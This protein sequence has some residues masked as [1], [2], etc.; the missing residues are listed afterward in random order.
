MVVCSICFCFVLLEFLFVLILIF[1]VFVFVCLF[2]VFGVLLFLERDQKTQS[3]ME[4]EV[5]T[6]SQELKKGKEYDQNIFM[7]SLLC[8]ITEY[9]GGGV[10]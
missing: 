4:K 1:L 6:I 5:R 2:L 3:C 10:R 8:L 7:K 9:G